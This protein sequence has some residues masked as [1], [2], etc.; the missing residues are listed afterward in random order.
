MVVNFY[1]DTSPAPGSVPHAN[2][3]GFR[4]DVSG[5][6]GFYPVLLIWTDS[7]AFAKSAQGGSPLYLLAWP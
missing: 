5:K 4:N 6:H 7:S 2:L 3:T 1:V